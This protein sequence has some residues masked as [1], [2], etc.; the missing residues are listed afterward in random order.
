VQPLI[1][2]A[3]KALLEEDNAQRTASASG[4]GGRCLSLG[5]LRWAHHVRDRVKERQLSRRE[6]DRRILANLNGGGYSSESDGARMNL[7]FSE[8]KK[9]LK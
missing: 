5:R 4:H 7:R 3:L 1:P 2:S 9:K 8:S 6:K